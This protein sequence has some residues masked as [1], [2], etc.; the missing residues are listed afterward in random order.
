M[1]SIKKRNNSYL[2]TVSCG[3]TSEGKKITKTMTYTPAPELSESKAQKEAEKQAILFE[4]SVKNGTVVADSRKKLDAFCYEYLMIMK[5]KLSP[6]TYQ[7]YTRTIANYIKPILGYMKL[8]DIKPVHVQNFI[9]EISK[10]KIVSSKSDGKITEKEVKLS[11]STVKRYLNVLQSM[12]T[13]AYKLGYINSNPTSV[14]KL[15]LA[16][17]VRPDIKIFTKQEAAQIIDCLKNEDLQFQVLIQLAI[18]TGA[19]RGE[20][21]ALKFSDFDREHLKVKIERSAYKN[22]GEEIGIKCPKGK[23]SRTVAVSEYCFDLI[24][25]LKKEKEADAL[26]LGEKWI[27]DEW[28]FTQWN[29]EIINPHTPTKQFAKFLKKNNIPHRKFHCLRH[30]SATLLLYGGMNIVHVQNRL[31]HAELETTQIYTHYI[32]EVDKTAANII[33]NILHP[34]KSVINVDR[35]ELPDKQEKNA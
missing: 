25:M 32:D 3:Y 18:I 12:M 26:R 35:N 14:D 30:T 2:I 33:D 24:D 1:A 27:G 17:T 6:T 28:V 9:S 21:T 15:T 13:C 20:L 22:P 31:G 23:K 4:D 29:G 34:Q 5:D 11:A 19:R 7:T 8:K 10:S 16:D